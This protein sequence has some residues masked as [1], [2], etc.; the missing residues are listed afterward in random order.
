MKLEASTRVSRGRSPGATAT[1]AGALKDSARMLCDL[2][3]W[4]IS[5][6]PLTSPRA[7]VDRLRAGDRRL[8]TPLPALLFDPLPDVVA[9]D[10]Q[11]HHGVQVLAALGLRQ[12]AARLAGALH[13]DRAVEL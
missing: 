1:G 7:A 8:A 11:G 12:L 10:G 13:P 6:G 4:A 3:G 2:G 9:L 5:P